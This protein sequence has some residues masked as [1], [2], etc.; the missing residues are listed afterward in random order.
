M[1]HHHDARLGRLGRD[2]LQ[3]A[4][5]LAGERTH[6]H[7]DLRRRRRHGVVLLGIHAKDAR[8]FCRAV[9]ADEAGPERDGHLAE[10]GARRTPAERSFDAIEQLDHLDLAAQDRVER[11]VSTFMHGKFPGAQMQVSGRF[12][13]A[14]ELGNSKRRE[15]RNGPDVVNGQHGSVEN[16]KA[17]T[18]RNDPQRLSYQAHRR[19]ALVGLPSRCALRYSP[20][21][22]PCGVIGLPSRC[23]L[24]YSP[25]GRPCGSLDYLRA[26]RFGI[27][28]WGGPAG[29]LDYLR[30]ARFGI[31]PWGGPAGSC[32]ATEFAWPR[33]RRTGGITERETG[34]GARGRSAGGRS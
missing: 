10:N 8:R 28:P 18:A 23:A 30:A 33:A 24:R 31:R 32:L 34:S 19:D 2:A 7:R 25:L 27:R 16:R 13:E 4:D 14:L 21:G 20:L 12:R 1:T 9:S 3:S 22:R 29:S 15:Q 26:A 6:L 11:P 17:R 5:A